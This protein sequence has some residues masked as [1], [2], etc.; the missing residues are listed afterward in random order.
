MSGTNAITLVACNYKK[1][2][3]LIESLVFRCNYN[4][5]LSIY[6]L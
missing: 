4:I 2:I 5:K 6:M 3:K 1:N